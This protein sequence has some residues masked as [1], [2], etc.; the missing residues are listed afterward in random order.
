MYTPY[1]SFTQALGIVNTENVLAT[2][3]AFQEGHLEEHNILIMMNTKGMFFF[4]LVNMQINNNQECA[5]FI[6]DIVDKEN[7]FIDTGICKTFQS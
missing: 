1:L 6:Q 2:T 5:S 3:K 4:L 7:T